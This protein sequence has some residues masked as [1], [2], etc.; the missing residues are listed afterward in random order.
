MRFSKTTFRK[1]LPLG[2]GIVLMGALAPGAMEAGAAAGDSSA[3]VCSTSPS[4]NF[5]LTARAGYITMPDGNS[6]YMWGY[7]KDN[8]PFQLPGPVL[9]VPQGVTVT[10]VL[11]NQLPEDTSIVF[12]GQ[13]GVQAGGADAQPQ[14]DGG[15]ALTSLTNV[16]PKLGGSVSY[17]FVASEPGTYLYRSGTDPDKQVQMGMY[18]ALVVRPSAHADWAYNR[19]DTAFNSTTEYMF[20]MSEI[21]PALHLAVERNR[22][23]DFNTYSAKYFLLN[24]RSMPDTLAPNGAAWLPAQPFGSVVQ[25]RPY[26]ATS[27]PRPAL[28]RYLN[29]GSG[30]VNYPLHPHGNDQRVIARDGRVLEG[31]TGQDLSFNKFLIDVGPGQ[32]FDA[33]LIWTDVEGWNPTTNPIPVPLPQQQNQ[34]VSGDTYYSGSPY[35]GYKNDLPVGITSNNQCGEY[36]HMAHSHALQQSTNYGASFGG[37]MTLIRIDPPAGCP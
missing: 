20:M 16:A 32:T 37:M 28:V 9:C 17:T 21:D 30:S 13:T 29:A 3:L 36:Y 22:S 31:D 11:Q 6:I 19:A 35:L 5:T 23:F 15:G 12:P 10:V 25:I 14:F 7:A 33:T 2:L 18:G 1:L 4:N 8:G 26:N 34:G 24:G 27:N